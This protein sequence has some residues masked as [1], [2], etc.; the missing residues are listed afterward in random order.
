MSSNFS[1]KLGYVKERAVN[2]IDMLRKGEF[3]LIL[4]NAKIELGHR[5]EAIRGKTRHSAIIAGRT[6]RISSRQLQ[7]KAREAQGK[8]G[9]MR[10]GSAAAS[11]AE[12]SFDDTPVDQV[13]PDSAFRN[14]RKLVPPS[15]RPTAA[16]LYHVSEMQIEKS[17]LLAHSGA[18]ADFVKPKSVA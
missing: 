11:T 6:V 18:I 15:H 8:L 14:R 12:Q 1:D 13:I 10:T 17:D 5:A 9:S 4:H 16:R 3:G 7:Q 2:A